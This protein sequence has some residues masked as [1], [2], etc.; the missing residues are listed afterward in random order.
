MKPFLRAM[1]ACAVLV[2]SLAPVATADAAVKASA[3]L[4]GAGDAIKLEVAVTSTKA[5]TAKTRPKR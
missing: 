4:V 2:T 1:T 3:K 5:F